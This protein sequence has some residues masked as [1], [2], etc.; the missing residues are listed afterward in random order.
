ML[1]ITA[2]VI[3]NILKLNQ[4][5]KPPPP[6]MKPPKPKN[7]KNCGAEFNPFKSTERVCSL[8]CALAGA[9][10]VVRGQNK[11]AVDKVM[12]ELKVKFKTKHKNLSEYEAEAK[13]EFQRWIRERDANLP[14]ISCGS[15]TSNPFW[16]GGHFKKAEL[17]S[18]VIFN[19]DN[20]HK[21]CR[22]CNY[23]LNGNELAYRDG[24]IKKIGVERVEALETFA[25]ET[26]MYKYTREELIELKKK[27]SKPFK[28]IGIYE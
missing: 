26:R 28:M 23:F 24:L 21:Q 25:N 2:N 13:K 1:F 11:A 14:C 9:K 4:K 8:Q 15:S 17:F 19:E 7:C 20:C 12:K 3:E 27:Y 16:D 6:K 22:K 10:V 18:G 5:Q